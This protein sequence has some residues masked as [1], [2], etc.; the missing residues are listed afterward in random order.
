MR[1]QAYCFHLCLVEVDERDH[2]EVSTEQHP[3]HVLS[4]VLWRV[5]LQLTTLVV[6]VAYQQGNFV[7]ARVIQVS[8]LV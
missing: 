6:L 5:Q 8:R 4:V 2:L 1:S 3:R 7:V